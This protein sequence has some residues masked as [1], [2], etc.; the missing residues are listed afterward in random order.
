MSLLLVG[1][2]VAWQGKYNMQ[3]K[4]NGIRETILSILMWLMFV[5]AVILFFTVGSLSD[6]YIFVLVFFVCTILAYSLMSYNPRCSPLRHDPK[7][8]LGDRL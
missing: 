7:S 5:P 4:G 3:I 8:L 1:K 2:T 6:N